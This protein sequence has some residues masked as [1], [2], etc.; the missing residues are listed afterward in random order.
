[1]PMNVIIIGIIVLVVLVIVIAFFAGG[2]SSVQNKIS[3]LFGGKIQG[4]AKDI[5]I[6]TCVNHCETAQSLPE[7]SRGSSSYCTSTFIVDTDSSS[8]TP[9]KKVKCGSVSSASTDVD[10][11]SSEAKRGVIAGDDLGVDCPVSCSA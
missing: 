10:S 1:M 2:F 4:Q 5:A 11:S 7:N 8:S 9:P 3:D 6:Q